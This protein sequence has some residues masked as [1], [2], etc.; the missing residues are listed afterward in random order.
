MYEDASYLEQPYFE[1]LKVGSPRDQEPWLVYARVLDRLA[2]IAPNRRLL[3]VGA[4]YGAFLEIARERGWDVAGVELSATAAAYAKT[5]RHIEMVVGTIEDAALPRASFGAVTLW[6]VIEHLSDPLRTLREIHDVLAPGGVLVVFTINQRSL[7]NRIG[8]LLHRVTG[9][10]AQRPLVLLYDIHHNFF[11]DRTTLTD[12]LRRA[13]FGEPV[14][15]DR[16]GANIDRWQNVPIP[17]VLAWGTK[18]LDVAARVL[19]GPYRMI[20]Y[21]Q[22]PR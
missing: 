14:A 20:V 17:P 7:I 4:S 13:G 22:K 1:R 2:G 16:L 8:H 3:D 19:G 12:T 9:G 11:F 6:D 18:V 10:A 5:T 15:E 21:V